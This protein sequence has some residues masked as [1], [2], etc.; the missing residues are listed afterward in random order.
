MSI[1]DFIDRNLVQLRQNGRELLK[2]DE[3]M[4]IQLK[5]VYWW[6]TSLKFIVTSYLNITVDFGLYHQFSRVVC[7]C[8]YNPVRSGIMSFVIVT[9]YLFNWFVFYHFHCN[10]FFI[11][12]GIFYLLPFS[13]LVFFS[14]FSH[15]FRFFFWLVF[16]QRLSFNYVE[17]LVFNKVSLNVTMVVHTM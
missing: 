15:S 10:F 2:L 13:Y 11:N 1:Q 4:A 16:I 9:G 6:L 7:V 3:S 12:F 14:N 5:I 17:A 8:A